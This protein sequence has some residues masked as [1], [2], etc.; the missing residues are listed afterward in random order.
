MFKTIKKH[1][2]ILRAITVVG[3]VGTLVTS[4]TYATL[5]SPTAALTGNSIQSATANLLVGTASAT[6]TAYGA[7]HSGFTFSNIVPGG[8]AIPTSGN[9]F[10][11]K[12]TGTTTLSLKLVVSGTP[13]NAG[14]IDLSKVNVQVTRTDTSTVQ[15]VS[16][17]TLM[18]NSASGGLALT[19]NLAPGSTG[20]QYTLA[21][22]MSADAYSGSGTGATVGP[23]DFVFSG[24]AVTP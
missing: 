20:V 1:A 16:L 7:T 12:N 14:N 24:T 19:D 18:D 17:Q 2:P 6:S 9:V 4:V 21:V 5:Q 15:T 13:T 10:Y 23:F 11:L 8:P 22:S 3:V